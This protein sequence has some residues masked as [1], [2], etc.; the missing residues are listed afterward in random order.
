MRP[1]AGFDQQ[2]RPLF[3]KLQYKFGLSALTATQNSTYMLL[4]RNVKGVIDPTTIQVNNHNSGF[5]TDGGSVCAPM[6]I[7]DKLRLSIKF[8]LTKHGANTNSLQAVKIMWIPVFF[9]FREKLD[10]TDDE[11]SETVAS[12]IDVIPEDTAEDVTPFYGNTKLP[13]SAG[14]SSI[15]QP[16]STATIAETIGFL[17]MDTSATMEHV[18]FDSVKFFDALKYYT[19]KGALKACIGRTRNFML[20]EHKSHQNFYIDKFVPRAI[21]RM[22]PFS[23]FAI[24]VHLPT[25]ADKDQMFYSQALTG[26]KADVGV[27]CTATYHEWNSDHDQTM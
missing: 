5:E 10:A 21:R 12:L 1:P 19:N 16:L 22:V 7:I 13:L 4:V 25:D 18:D 9:S 17:N 15:D 6:S 3:H 2:K 20:S 11:T 26:L 24:L 23:F 8:V 27:T 14:N